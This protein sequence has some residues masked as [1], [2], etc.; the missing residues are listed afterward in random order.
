MNP[1]VEAPASRHMRPAGSR[2]NCGERVLELPA[3]ARH[4]PRA[5]GDL[6]RDVLGDHLA[7]LLGA[8]ALTSQAD[9]AGQHGGRGAR[10]RLEQAPLGQNGV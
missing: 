2:P 5:L 9:V 10:A 3:A 7:G 1:P 8:A 4:E 6:D